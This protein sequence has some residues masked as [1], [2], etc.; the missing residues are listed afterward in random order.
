MVNKLNTHLG[1][2]FTEKVSV[3]CLGESKRVW[4]WSPVVGYR[5]RWAVGSHTPDNMILG[6]NNRHEEGGIS[7]GGQSPTAQSF[8]WNKTS[9]LEASDKAL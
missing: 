8:L 3:V 1:T 4:M 6:P 7:V 9:A 2:L 5:C